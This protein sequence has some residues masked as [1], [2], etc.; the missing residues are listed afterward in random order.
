MELQRINN[1]LAPSFSAVKDNSTIQTELIT[2]LLT[3]S[4][5]ECR[6]ISRA[7]II[8]TYADYIEK[9]CGYHYAEVWKG[10]GQGYKKEKITRDEFIMLWHI[11]SKST[12]WFK[13]NLGS[14]ILRGKLLVLPII[15]L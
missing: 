1:V 6:P 14:A 13:T 3:K 12:Q 4:I 10:V 7:D 9:R 8:N 15:E 5:Q 2:Q 11:K